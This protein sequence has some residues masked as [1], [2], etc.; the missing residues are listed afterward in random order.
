MAIRPYRVYGSAPFAL[1]AISASFGGLNSQSS[2][3]IATEKLNLKGSKS[4]PKNLKC[5]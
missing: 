4:Q 5:D 3:S 1:T 2:Q